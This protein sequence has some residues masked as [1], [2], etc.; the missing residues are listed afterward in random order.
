M[1]MITPTILR[2]FARAAVAL[3]AISTMT[4][5]APSISVAA[6]GPIA[7]VAAEN[8]YGGIARQIGGDR[9]TVTSIMSNP[10]QDPHLF[11]TTPGIVRQIAD[12]RI[13]IVNG[14][15]YD[16]WMDK[17][18][19]AAPRPGRSVIRAAQLV[20]ATPGSNPHLWYAPATMPAVAKAIAATLTQADSA[21]AA[22]YAARLKTVLGQLDRVEQ[23]AAQLRAKHKGQA[24]TATE[25]VFGLMAEALGLTVRNQGFQLA[26]MNDTEPSV[27]EIAAFEDDLKTHKVKALIYNRQVSEKLTERLLDI[28]RKSKVPVVAVT[29]TQ[30]AYA[31]FPDW[32]LSEMNALDKALSGPNS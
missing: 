11:E 4:L 32:M 21:H 22:D 9:I 5:T 27:S 7:V 13:V 23:R 3:G 1:P 14:A 31:T 28:A 17:L 2:N 6:D 8:F 15:D 29:E 12:A 19:A 20:G 25:P 18:L 24:V 16:P 10:D 30:P 26:M